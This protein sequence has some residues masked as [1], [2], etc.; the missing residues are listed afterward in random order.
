M[1]M[2][3]QLP[4]L[5]SGGGVPPIVTSIAFA[6]IAAAVLAILCERVRLPSI[7]AFIFAGLVIG[8]VGLELINEPEQ[9]ET[10]AGLGLVLLLFLIGLE[11][12]LHALLASGRTLIVSGLLQVPLTLGVAFAVFMG[13]GALG[14]GSGDLY[15][16]MYFALACAFSST[17][18]VV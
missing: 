5:A 17:L 11:L 16:T 7:A 14:F 4:L 1:G 15:P 3:E 13:A 18:L 12:D 8:P 6:F 10:I 9:I 2:L